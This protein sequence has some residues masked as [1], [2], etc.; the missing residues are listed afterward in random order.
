MLARAT[1]SHIFPVL[2]TGSVSAEMW[3]LLTET[4]RTTTLFQMTETDII[5]KL[6]WKGCDFHRHFY[7]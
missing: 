2:L 7:H 5:F 3:A 4:D 1:L 6:I